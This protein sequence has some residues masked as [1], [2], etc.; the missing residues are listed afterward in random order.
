M[1]YLILALLLTSCAVNPSVVVG[2]GSSVILNSG[3]MSPNYVN[4]S[5]LLP[6]ADAY[7]LQ[8]G[9]HARFSGRTSLDEWGF[10]CVN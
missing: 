8:Q 4:V 2:T 10:D 3:S 1:R 6:T 7:C 5:E 9:K